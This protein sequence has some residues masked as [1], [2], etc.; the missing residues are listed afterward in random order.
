MVINAI[1]ELIRKGELTSDIH[2]DFVK[3]KNRGVCVRMWTGYLHHASN[4]AI[5][6]VNEILA[7][8]ERPVIEGAR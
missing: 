4:I 8:L 1:N 6:P 3:D 7:A 2:Y 5:V